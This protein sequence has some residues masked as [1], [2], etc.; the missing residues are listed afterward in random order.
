VVFVID[1]PGEF[2]EKGFIKAE[3]IARLKRRARK[4]FS[5][6]NFLGGF[7]EGIS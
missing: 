3:E 7:I 4:Q 5:S 2:H 6:I 1:R